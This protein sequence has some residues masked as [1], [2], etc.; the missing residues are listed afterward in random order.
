MLQSL[1]DSIASVPKKMVETY[2]YNYECGFSKDY[3]RVLTGDLCSLQIP[4]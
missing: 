1:L 3:L 2:V 4:S